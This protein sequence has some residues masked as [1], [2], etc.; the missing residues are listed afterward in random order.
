MS[1]LTQGAP[2][3]TATAAS[4]LLLSGAPYLYILPT[5]DRTR[6][7]LG[8]TIT[9]FNRI[10]AL[11]YRYPE[12]DLRRSVMIGVDDGSLEYVLHHVF[13]LRRTPLAGRQDG[14]TE[15]F[16]GDFVEEV[17]EFIERIGEV[18]GKTYPVYRDL[19]VLIRAHR[20]RCPQAGVRPP[21]EDSTARQAR[22]A[23]DAEQ[24]LAQVLEQTEQAIAR[25]VSF[26]FDTLVRGERHC[27]LARTVHRGSEPDAWDMAWPREATFRSR[28]LVAVAQISVTVGTSSCTFSLLD[29]PFCTVLNDQ[30]AYETFRISQGPEERLIADAPNPVDAAFAWLW[31]ALAP[32]PVRPLETRRRTMARRA[33]RR[34]VT[35]IRRL[36]A[37]LG[38]SRR[39]KSPA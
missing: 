28:D 15:W 17:L 36:R 4:P 10:V 20:A 8:R 39:L 9:D 18:R 37:A 27:Y 13:G 16:A 11:T 33:R 3:P 21:R 34:R 31:S 19:D 38:T 12:I 25:I 1:I 5:L 26:G 32:L 22:A 23:R 14:H 6:L 35:P 24:L 2:A 30:R 7:K 29:T